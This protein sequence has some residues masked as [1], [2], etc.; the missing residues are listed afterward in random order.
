M[1]QLLFTAVELFYMTLQYPEELSVYLDKIPEIKILEKI[2]VF[3]VSL[4]AAAG[5]YNLRD[6]YSSS[7]A[8]HLLMLTGAIYLFLYFIIVLFASLFESFIQKTNPAKSGSGN[9]ARSIFTLGILPL[10]FFQPASVV[11]S[12]LE[13]P[14]F[15]ILP[16]FSFLLFW[17][18]QIHL[19]SLQYL[20]ELSMQQTVKFYFMSLLYLIAF[21]FLIIALLIVMGI[22]L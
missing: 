4:S 2:V 8:V 18:I 11:S 3:L 1:K 14:V 7:Y 13:K 6:Y 12:M 16:I 10:V 19:K 15:L 17:C 22:S 9:Q 20:Y 5:L 21:P